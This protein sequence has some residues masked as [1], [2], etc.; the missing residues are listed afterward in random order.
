[1]KK[2]IRNLSLSAGKINRRH[3]Q[4]ILALVILS[5]LVLGAGAPG[6]DGGPGGW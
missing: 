4:I 2:I 1:M 3:V 5:L 6:V